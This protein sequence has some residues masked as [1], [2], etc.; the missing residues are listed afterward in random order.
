[1]GKIK[2][3]VVGVGRGGMMMSYCEKEQHAKLVAI[4]DKWA[5]GLEIKKNELNDPDISYYTDY[6]DFLKHDM[7]VVMLANYAHQHA[8]FA[9]KAMK[10][11]FHVISEV[12]PCLTMKEAVEL[13]E[14]IEQTG[15]TYCYAE[16]YCYMPG[17]YE[18]RR[19]YKSGVIGELDYCEGEYV[20]N[21]EE[22]WTDLTY[23]DP[24]HWRNLMHST[25]YCTHSLGP[26][27]HISGQRPTRVSGFEFL[28]NDANVR[29][30]RKCRGG[31]EMVT[32]E[33]GATGKSIHGDLQRNNIS[34]IIYGTKGRLETARECTQMGDVS[35]IYVEYNEVEGD[36]STCKR[37]VYDPKDEKSAVAAQFGHGGSDYYCIYNA[38]EKIAGNPDAD[39]ID[40]YEA[41]D[42]YLPG[43]FAHR[44]IL[45]G[46]IPMEIPDLRDRAERDKWRHDTTCVI[47]EVA[48]DML[49]PAYSK[50][51]QPIPDEVFAR[52]QTE[53][54]QH[55]TQR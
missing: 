19:L 25:F 55:H 10:A 14:T 41:M 20:H 46:G 8:P 24:N 1:M 53:W 42:M 47:P 27:V 38:L 23:G 44:S 49:V 11:G 18:M 43:M 15:K 3:G 12:L 54:Q 34:Y 7:D 37:E 5:E 35:K 52:R 51:D 48:G 17:P 6:E 39:A 26:L 36:Y 22:F 33:G 50:G 4:C 31:I 30:G 28:F 40:V 13:I 9:I 29:C 45:A 21:C 2:V 32:F 16:N